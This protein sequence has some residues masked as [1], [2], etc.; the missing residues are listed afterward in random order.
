[1]N[2][3][4]KKEVNQT[5]EVTP[6]LLSITKEG[7]FKLTPEFLKDDCIIKVHK[8]SKK[9]VKHLQVIH[10]TDIVKTMNGYFVHLLVPTTTCKKI[11][12]YEAMGGVDLGIRTLATTYIHN[13]TTHETKILEYE[14]RVDLIKKY[15]EKIKRLKAN[16]LKTRKG[17][18]RKK[19]LSKLEK[20][21]KHLVDA[22]HWDFINNL[23]SQADVIYLGDIKSHDIVTGGKNRTLNQ[24]FNDLKFHQLKQRL[25]Y[26][27]GLADRIV[28]LVTEPYTTKTC[29]TCGTINDHVGSS[30]VF[31]CPCCHL[32]TG[33]DMNASKNMTMKGIFE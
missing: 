1:M 13:V 8:H 11:K 22:L 9:K 24:A 18:I 3:K 15:N 16:K 33:R 4:K 29:S 26:K 30:K 17:R 28:K 5:I 7:D 10:N 14:H 6:K 19:F 12:R 20:K 25:V 2:F 23:L 27:A 31:Q 21:K 32:T